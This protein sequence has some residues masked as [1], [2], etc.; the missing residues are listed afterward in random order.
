MKNKTQV[1]VIGGGPAGIAAA[2]TVAKAGKEVILIERGNFAG[3]KNMFGG[4]IYTLPTKEI[5]PN[6]ET[7]A[8]LERKIT[9]HKYFI[10]NNSK[11]LSIEYFDNEH[12]N[13]YTIIRSKFDRYMQKEAENAGVIFVTETLVEDLIIENKKVIG[14]KT[15]LEKYYADIVIIA[16]GVN[17]LLAKKG[18][19]RKIFKP[20]DMVL[21]VKEVIKLDSNKIDERFN[22]SN[23][24]GSAFEIFGEPME[25]IFGVGYLYTNKESIAIGIGASLEDLAKLKLK[26]YELLDKMKE[27]P[28]FKNLLKDGELLEYSAHLIPEGGYKGIPTIYSDGVMIVGDAAMFVNGIHFEGTNF[29][30][31]SGKFA[32]ET[33]VEALNKQDFS[34]KQLSLYKKKLQK[35][36]IIKDLQAYK[37][38]I[39][40]INK[41]KSSF[42]DYYLSKILE[43]FNIFTTTDSIPKREKYQKYVLSFFTDRCCCKLIKEMFD[44]LKMVIGVLCGK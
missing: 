33:A 30:L 43:F 10:R 9:N 35:S 44:L 41:H 38:I 22:L 36:F 12:N 6:F 11:E 31:I 28:K 23:N 18:N 7:D 2:I 19:L 4:A 32:G 39:P 40:T 3:A 26:P 29:A 42:L 27:H 13:A 15:E 37:N 34:S 1:I 17:S 8:P 20:K 14:V 21:S 24:E 5:F 25:G 16:D